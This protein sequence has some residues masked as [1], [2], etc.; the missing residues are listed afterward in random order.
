MR[1]GDL[2][3]GV[4]LIITLS[5]WLTLFRVALGHESRIPRTWIKYLMGV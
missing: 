5:S 2:L 4:P 3:G 1:D